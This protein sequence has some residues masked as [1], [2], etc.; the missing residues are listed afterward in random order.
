MRRIT[1]T[2][3]ER[4]IYVPR[5]S[6]TERSVE[7]TV[8]TYWRLTE[9]EVTF[10]SL[11]SEFGLRPVWHQLSKR[12]EGHLF[13]AVLALFGVNVIRTH[14]IHYKWVTLRHKLGRWQRAI[15][16]MTTIGGSRIEVRCD[17]RPDPAAAALGKAAGTPYA[18]AAHPKTG[19]TITVR[20][21]PAIP[22]T[23]KCST[24]SDPTVW[25]DSYISMTYWIEFV[26][27]VEFGL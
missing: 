17:I 19:E 15:T 14:G 24:I 23:L 3:P 10:R 16:A 5:T 18:P 1:R 7:D 2:I 20:L 6:H 12:T 26:K 25:R 27:S 8:R 22:H 13:I 9:L 4:A 11:K 21:L